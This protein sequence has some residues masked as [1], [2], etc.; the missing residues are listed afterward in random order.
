MEIIAKT[1]A[2]RL[3]LFHLLSLYFHKEAED[4]SISA[5]EKNDLFAITLRKGLSSFT[6]EEPIRLDLHKELPRA[7]NASLG[8]A[9]HKAALH[10]A[11]AI[12]PYG[13]LFGVRPV[14]VPL[15]YLKNGYSE[16]ETKRILKEE[17]FVSEEKAKLLILLAKKEALFE[18]DLEKEDAMLYLSIPFCPSRCHYCSFIS[19]AAPSHLKLI[20]SYLS[21]MKEE[22]RLTAKL[23]K[24]K[25]KRLGAV[26]MGGGTPGILSAEQMEEI[27]FLVKEEFDFS[28]VREF[29]V[30][31]GR[32][33]TVT[34]EKL[35]VLKK[36]GVDR[37]SINPQTTCDQTL[38]RIGRNHTKE[39]FLTAFGLAKT[40]G[41][42]SINC[43][44]I[45]GLEGETPEQ[46][47]F[48]LS[49]VLSLSPDEI[50]LHA[51][52]KKRSAESE[53]EEIEGKSW[54]EAMTKAHAICINE[55][56]EPYYLYRQKNA[57]A[58][59]E[60]TGFAKKGTLGVYNLAMMEDLCDIFA[61]GAGAIAKL[62][63]K[64]KGEKIR[65]FPGFKYPFEYLSCPEKTEEK[66]KD[67]AR[68]L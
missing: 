41:F 5:E 12:P 33:D 45:A 3:N 10:F 21:Q 23:F 60:N 17:F 34:K 31:I 16:E 32:P 4:F 35:L 43:D 14:K 24:E 66:I 30:E 56:L 11:P 52:C 57:A 36:M 55:G 65:R 9:F 53:P 39:D 13:L 40:I 46:F 29:C 22:I 7:K 27:L 38:R 48:S 37:I 51:L 64:E 2:E 25:G 6:E 26:Y 61:C 8:K 68:Y 20:P 54:Q 62:L 49:E 18:K 15:F 58:D 28:F 63:P 67:M 44:L 59:L 47:L 42:S 19:S 50:T 1:E